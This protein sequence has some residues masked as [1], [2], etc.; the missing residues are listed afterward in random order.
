[1]FPTRRLAI[2]AYSPYPG[3]SWE[4]VWAETSPG[5]LGMS[6]KKIREELF[7]AAPRISEMV[8]DAE[9]R[10]REEEARWAEEE[11]K[12]RIRDAQR[13]YGEAIKA[14]QAELLSTIEE[15][16]L[17]VRVEQFF[18]DV[19]RRATRLPVEEQ[20]ALALQASKAKG[21]LGSTDAVQ[22][23]RSWQAPVERLRPEQLALLT[24][25]GS[26]PSA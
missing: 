24:T 8:I 19:A 20:K 12:R 4:K 17:A 5:R 3:T 26:P 7:K 14:S 23:L 10:R 21:L 15:W 1:M 11:R 22:R 6:L 2:R 16:S 13:A 9:R 18:D 25:E